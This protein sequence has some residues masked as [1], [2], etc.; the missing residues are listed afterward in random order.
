MRG[1]E[2]AANGVVSSFGGRMR[3]RNESVRELSRAEGSPVKKGP[4]IDRCRCRTAVDRRYCISK[5]D[6]W[7]HCDL[8]IHGP[9]SL[10]GF[11]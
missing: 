3:V 4:D 10:L 6:G 11:K 9:S 2:E 1:H 5:H 7:N 8:Q